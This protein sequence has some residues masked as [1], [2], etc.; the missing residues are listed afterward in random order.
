MR[1]VSRR[2]F[3]QIAGGGLATTVLSDSIARAL[4]VPANQATRSLKDVEHIVV[5]TQENRSFDARRSRVRR[6]ASGDRG[7]P[8]DRD[9]TPRPGEIR[10]QPPWPQRLLPPLRRLAQ[11]DAARQ[12]AGSR[13]RR[14]AHTRDRRR[15][16]AAGHGPPRRRVRHGPAPQGARHGRDHD[17][18]RHSGGWYDIALTTPSDA[19]SATSSRA[20]WSPAS[21]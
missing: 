13:S 1:A 3:L 7:W 5:L 17:R 16:P 21:G 6:S 10:P 20:G 18:T 15:L 2:R 9:R 11:G 8:S 4:V 14:H 12:G 19:S